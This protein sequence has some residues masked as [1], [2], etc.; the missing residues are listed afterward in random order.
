MF[1]QT[2]TT[3]HLFWLFIDG[4]WVC[5]FCLLGVPIRIVNRMI[6]LFAEPDHT[7][8]LM[9]TLLSGIER[10]SWHDPPPEWG[11]IL[12]SPDQVTLPAQCPPLQPFLT[13]EQ[14]LISSSSSRYWQTSRR[15]A[16]E[17]LIKGAI[18]WQFCSWITQTE[19]LGWLTVRFADMIPNWGALIAGAKVLAMGYGY[20]EI[21][22]LV[23]NTLF[24]AVKWELLILKLDDNNRSL[25]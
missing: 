12:F 20:S 9:H 5:I 24:A 16:W 22:N 17:L 19:M 3:K 13:V 1:T 21:R 10:S 15:L 7:L 8:S 11:R 23:W 14:P 25:W 4:Q 18:I 2:E 6:A